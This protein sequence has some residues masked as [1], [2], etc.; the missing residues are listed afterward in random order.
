VEVRP[1]EVVDAFD[2]IWRTRLHGQGGPSVLP[3]NNFI[4]GPQVEA[5]LHQQAANNFARWQAHQPGEER[6]DVLG[7]VA[8]ACVEI[9]TIQPMAALREHMVRHL[10]ERLGFEDKH[11]SAL[12]CSWM[13][14]ETVLLDD[15]D[16][17]LRPNPAHPF[18]SIR[19]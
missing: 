7:K 8:R 4:S 2:I 6:A 3:V 18:A 10:A 12:L 5:E 9:W 15:G 13:I 1:G 19:L 17:R 14:Y 16:G 11:I